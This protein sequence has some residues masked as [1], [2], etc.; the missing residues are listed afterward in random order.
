MCIHCVKV[1]LFV[2]SMAD[3]PFVGTYG[4]LIPFSELG[5]QTIQFVKDNVVDEHLL[6]N[7]AIHKGDP[8]EPDPHITVHMGLDAFQASVAYMFI[9]EKCH[10]FEVTLGKFTFFSISKKLDDGTLHEYDVLVREIESSELF[11]L[12]TNITTKTG[13]AWHHPE[14]KSHL[15]YAYLKYGTGKAYAQRFNE[16]LLL[17]KNREKVDCIVM[18]KFQEKTVVQVKLLQET[19]DSTRSSK[20]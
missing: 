4:V 8:F 14:Y 16:H 15:T 11:Q 7:P 17:Q 20:S 12:H 2:F 10:P 6:K 13:K 5:N 9:K 18:K 19:I 1:T 3:A